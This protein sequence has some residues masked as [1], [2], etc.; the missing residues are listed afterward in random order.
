MKKVLSEQELLRREAL[1]ELRAKGINP[2]P[3]EQF[4]IN[5]NSK[6]IKDNFVEGSKDF[7]EVII[8]GRL[9]N[10]RIMGS[11]SFAEIQDSSGKIQIYLNRDD[12]CEGDDK[13]LYNEVFKK[14]LDIGDI[15]GISGRVFK[16]KV[17]ETSVFVKTLKLL[18]KS[19]KPLPI[20]KVDKEGHSHDAFVDLSLIHI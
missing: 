12:L 2:F 4:K 7:E 20:V 8:A 14:H 19:L 16:T 15:L 6:E 3:A 5:S 9:M 17:G 11:A 10:R 1:V 13:S 18:T